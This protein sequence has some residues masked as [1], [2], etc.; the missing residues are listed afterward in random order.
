MVEVLVVEDDKDIQELISRYLSTL[1]VKLRFVSSGE[2][3]VRVYEEMVRGGGRPAVVVMDLQLP[4]ID[5]VE[6]TRRICE[7]DRDAV[8]YG[9]TAFFETE[10][11]ERLRDAGAK[12]VIG[13][14]VGMVGFRD[15]IKEILK[16]K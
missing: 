3:G 14:P 7:F 10:W 6:A 4:G 13:R 2:E 8:V 1:G 9:F 15:K 16:I 12:G 11:A 5:G